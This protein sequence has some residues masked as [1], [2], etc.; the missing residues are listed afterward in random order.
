[1]TIR[2]TLTGLLF[3]TLMSLVN[4]SRAQVAEKKA[5]TLDGAK[6]IIA[7]AVADARAKNA[8]G[9][10]IAVVDDGG[11]LLALER[12]DNTFA[13]A[14]NIAI[15]KAR[16]AAIFKRSTKVFEDA[17]KA[18]RTSMVAL[19][20]FTP[21]QGGVPITVA[22]QV[23]GAVGISGAASAQQDEEIALVAANAAQ[24]F[25]AHAHMSSAADV[26]YITSPNVAAAFAKGAPLLE[27]NG[28]KIH[29]SRR[30][31]PGIAEIHERDTDIIYVLDGTAT[32]VTGGAA[33]EATTVAPEE[34]RGKAIQGG[35]SRQL[36]KG[37]LIV[38]PHGVPHWFQEVKGPFT[39]YVVKVRAADGGA[40]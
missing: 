7:A 2:S 34:I 5:L 17:I 10:A 12:L 30:D 23:L 38:V 35:Q 4:T 37:D 21:L 29:A 27:V 24:S 16:T 33:V 31:A 20:D 25:M 8:P 15:G 22:G 6:T 13:A 32:L 1:M 39:Y 40:K 14:A 3:V 19:S 11:N 36:V 9:A 28:Y 26:T 18:G